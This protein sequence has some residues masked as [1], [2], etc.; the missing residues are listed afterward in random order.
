ML[1]ALR[2]RY[3]LL[4]V[5]TLVLVL[6]GDARVLLQIG[7]EIDRFH[8]HVE[9][10]SDRALIGR[11]VVDS[12]ILSSLSDALARLEHSCVAGI[13]AWLVGR[14]RSSDPWHGRKLLQSHFQIGQLDISFLR[15]SVQKT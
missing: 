1:G 13:V 7:I 2:V 14:A 9:R 3:E 11:S 8:V 12:S 4:L 6:T 15:S 5:L 10:R